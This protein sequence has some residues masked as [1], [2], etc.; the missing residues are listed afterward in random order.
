MRQRR[1]WRVFWINVSDGVSFMVLV[2]SSLMGVCGCSFLQRGGEKNA[3][4]AAPRGERGYC[5]RRLEERDLFMGR[6]DDGERIN[7]SGE[8]EE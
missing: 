6:D 5:E 7:T 4:L 3:A 2:Y 8:Q 1:V